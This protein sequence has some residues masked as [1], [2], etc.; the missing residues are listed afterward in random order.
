MK[1]NYLF[2]F[3]MVVFLGLIF[4]I[5]QYYNVLKLEDV[6]SASVIP[7]PGHSWDEM[8]CSSDILCIDATNK[9]IG[10]GT[11]TPTQL[12]DVNGNARINGN[13][14]LT[15]QI[16][17]TVVGVCGTKNGKYATSTPTGTEA[18]ATGTITG[19]TGSYVWTC[20]GSNGGADSGTCSTVVAN[21][22]TA[23]FA[24]VGNHVW[25]APSNVTSIE[26]LV[27]GGGGSGGVGYGGGG[28]GGFLTGTMFVSVGSAYSITVGDGGV[29]TASN[30]SGAYGKNGGNSNFST[31]IATGGGGGGYTTKSGL[32]GG[33][34]GGGGGD[35]G[36]T[37]VGG[38]SD[39]LS[40]KQGYDGGNGSSGNSGYER[41]GGGGGA[42]GSGGAGGHSS[43]GIGGVGMQSSIA[44]TSVYYAGGGGGG[45][46]AGGGGAG[47]SGGGGAGSQSSPVNGVNGSGG[48]GGGRDYYGTGS[49]G[50]S[51]IVILR[52]INN[53]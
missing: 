35:N 1:K 16:I 23:S 9:K 7:N 36:A 24:T 37:T 30:S 20:A 39:Y 26:Y 41:G 5:Y 40:P 34:G 17:T 15:G 33:S 50:G 10:I 28:G 3:S 52:Y 48:G 44:G 8:E 31:I 22:G 42:G 21:Y 25:T 38:D 11:D 46:S 4:S 6:S 53:Y 49:T 43:G 19:M 27:V 45:S 12:L 14:Y 47:G 32:A 51:G 18:C 13:L 2:I 29:A